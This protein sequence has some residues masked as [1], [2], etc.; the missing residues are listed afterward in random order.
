[1]EYEGITINQLHLSR[2]S[3][4]DLEFTDCC[5]QDCVFQEVT[6]Q[7]C[8]FSG[9]RF[10]N[11]SVVSLTSRYSH[12]RTAELES[13]SL[14]G[15]HW[16]DLLPSGIILEPISRLSGC[17]LKYNLFDGMK[18]SRFDFSKNTILDSAFEDCVLRE[19]SFHGSSLERTQF[20]HC[21][22]TKAD[23]REAGGYL[24]DL[25]SNRLRGAKFSFPEVLRLLDGTGVVIE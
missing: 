16:A 10:V 17:L 20:S 23:F 11:C 4:E 12:I 22:L 13:C 7:S 18:L 9:C 6:I 2:E 5:F 24:I 14:I 8:V 1:M 3:L 15:V 19:S 25:S 21:D